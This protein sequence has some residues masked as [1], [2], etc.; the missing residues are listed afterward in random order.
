MGEHG[1]FSKFSN[2]DIATRVPLIIHVPKLSNKKVV[3][4]NIVELVDLFPTLVDL[5]S[6][7]KPIPQ[8]KS[9]NNIL[10]TEGKS[11]A[12]LMFSKANNKDVSN[13]TILIIP[14]LIKIF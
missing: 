6:I 1:E 8:C 4:E 12:P 7:S 10:C 5:A 9:K 13:S 3:I 2:Y 14:R 11:L